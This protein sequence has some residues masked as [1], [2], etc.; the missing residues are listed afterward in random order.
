MATQTAIRD[1]LDRAAQETLGHPLPISVD[2]QISGNR[3]TMVGPM[4][5]GKTRTAKALLAQI[6][7]NLRVFTGTC[8]HD[9]QEEYA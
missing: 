2:V 3:L 7:G 6:G 1:A 5:T 9:L 8:N 4:A